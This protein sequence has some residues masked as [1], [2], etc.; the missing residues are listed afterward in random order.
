MTE[1]TRQEHDT[2]GPVTIPGDRYWG[3]QTG[4]CLEN[5]P[6]GDERMPPLFI[7]ALGLQKQAAARAN[8]DLDQLDPDLAEAMD[9]AAADV[10]QGRLNDHFP[11]PVWQSGSGTQ[12]NMNAN[13]VI[14]NRAAELLGRPMGAK[15]PVHPNDH[16]NLGQSSND[17]IPTVMHVAA[18]LG[19][20]ESLLPAVD[21]ME[22]CCL[23]QSEKCADIIK[24][25]RTHLQD[26]VP[27]TFGQE[28]AAWAFQL[29]QARTRL[30]R[31]GDD[32]LPI[33]QGGT[34]VGTGLST[35]PAFGARVADHLHRL[36]GHAFRPM[37]NAFAGIA[38]HD[39][40][41][42]LSA[43]L[44]TL[45]TIANK[46]ANDVRFYGSGPR[47]GLGEVILPKNE[48]GSSIMAGKVNPTQAESLTMVAARVMGGHS[49]VAMAAA[50]GQ[51]QLNAFKPLIAHTV[52]TS[53]T[54]LADSLTSFTDRCLAG[55]EPVVARMEENVH[56]SLMLATPLIGEIGYDR[57]AEIVERA[58]SQGVS[59]REAA[60]A[61]EYLDGATFDRVVDPVVMARGHG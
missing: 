50:G 49:T 61:L 57:T 21:H 42:A 10:A 51:F 52:L 25:G 29:R 5:F 46:I 17:T 60:L 44:A 26:A 34:A 7:R 45:A 35:H 30:A 55:L 14:A 56:R 19:L 1:E 6:V 53:L 16:V 4:R 9:A 36:T 20:W 13:E 59:L 41:V 18:R 58:H 2:L 3:A 47:A 40:L 23:E 39:A 38:A 22:S 12:S 27:M 33:P 43:D 11:L 28:W 54:L 15:D 8:R 37:D 32:L 31:A 48:P 24:L